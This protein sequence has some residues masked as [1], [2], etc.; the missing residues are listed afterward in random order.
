MDHRL[1]GAV[2]ED[3]PIKQRS[4]QVRGVILVEL[5]SDSRLARRGMRP[6]DIVIGA[7]RNRIGN[8]EEFREVV[9]SINGTLYLEVLR[10]GRDYVVRV[11]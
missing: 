9:G 11:D 8:L 5:K 2:F 3:I 6:G 10:K 1:E 4:S 7:N